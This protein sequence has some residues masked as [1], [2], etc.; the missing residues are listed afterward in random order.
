MPIFFLRLLAIS[1]CLSFVFGAVPRE[2]PA[3]FAGHA[4]RGG[5]VNYA[6]VRARVTHGFAEKANEMADAIAVLQDLSR[7]TLGLTEDITKHCS[8]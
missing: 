3:A 7:A 2:S 1:A 5:V 8:K 4:K 6:E